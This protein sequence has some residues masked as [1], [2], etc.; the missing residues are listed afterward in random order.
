MQDKLVCICENYQGLGDIGN[1]IIECHCTTVGKITDRSE[2]LAQLVYDRLGQEGLDG[3][4]FNAKLDEWD[5][6]Y[7]GVGYW[8]IETT[9]CKN[10]GNCVGCDYHWY[11]TSGSVDE[12]G[13]YWEAVA[14]AWNEM[15]AHL[16]RA[17]T[18]EER[19]WLINTIYK[20]RLDDE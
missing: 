15:E 7:V 20:C 14:T 17:V 16:G 9:T 19:R 11:S 13:M 12:D 8:T 3:L 4:I 1:P 10:N 18:E 5:A 6:L 2:P